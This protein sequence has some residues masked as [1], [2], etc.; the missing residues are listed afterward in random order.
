MR[1]F[2]ATEAHEVRDRYGPQ[3]ESSKTGFRYG[4]EFEPH[5]ADRYGPEFKPNGALFSVFAGQPLFL[6]AR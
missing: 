3:I 5:G 2:T 4:P 6:K 1:I